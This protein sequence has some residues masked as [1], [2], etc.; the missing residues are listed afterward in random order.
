MFPWVYGFKWSAGH[1][2]FLS[3]FFSVLGTVSGSVVT[4]AFR[5]AKDLRQRTADA[6]RWEMEFEELPRKARSCRHEITGE[7]RHRTCDHEFDCRTC[8]VHP[9]FLAQAAATSRPEDPAAGTFGLAMPTDR[10]YHRGHAWVKPEG[11]GTCTIGL[12]DFGA[13]LVGTPDAVELPLPGTHLNA[14]GTGWHFVRGGERLRILS[15]V[16]GEVLKQGSMDQGWL[17]RVRADDSEP[18]TRHLLRGGE[19]RP[20]IM[21]E[22]ERLEFSLG[23]SGVGATLADG[24]EMVSDLRAAYPGVA[25][26][27]FCSPFFLEG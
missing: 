4:A 20:W 21:H 19:V 14:N 13:R 22:L 24:G 23:S 18:A 6:M 1:L 12:D 15:P 25:W 17:L 10:L 26:E 16:D 9:T 5:S 27:S 8:S 7:V 2:I 3:V 11:D